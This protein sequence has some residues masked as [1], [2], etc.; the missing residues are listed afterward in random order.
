[1]VELIRLAVSFFKVGLLS[2]GGGYTL[3]PIIKNEV[4]INNNWLL[5][6]EFLQIL[7]VTQGIPG[8]ISVK[9][10]TYTGYKV[11]GPIGV[12]VAVTASMIVPIVLML[13]LYNVLLRMDKIPYSENFI[14]G[15]QF[16]TVGLLV[17]FA[18]RAISGAGFEL[19]GVLVAAVAFMV[20]AFTKVDVAAVIIGAGLI[21]LFLFR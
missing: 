15:V 21:G 2:I 11:A 20:M 10:A 9:L 16:A 8:A 1:M 12:F 5:E 3:I 6:E 19:K 18:Y 4:V 17:S 13:L 14:K 7:G